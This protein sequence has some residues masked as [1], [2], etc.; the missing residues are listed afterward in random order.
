[1]KAFI[2][3][4]LFVLAHGRCSW[5]SPNAMFPRRLVR[6]ELRN[7]TFR[8]RRRL[9]LARSKYADDHKE[10]LKSIYQVSTK[11]DKNVH[12]VTGAD[13]E[14]N[15]DQAIHPNAM[16]GG[17][18]VYN[19]Y[20]NGLDDKGHTQYTL[21]FDRKFAISGKMY[22]YVAAEPSVLFRQVDLSGSEDEVV[23]ARFTHELAAAL[24]YVDEIKVWIAVTT[25]CMEG[26]ELARIPFNFHV[27]AAYDLYHGYENKL[28][29]NSTSVYSSEGWISRASIIMHPAFHMHINVSHHFVRSECGQ[30]WIDSSLRVV[31]TSQFTYWNHTS[32]KYFVSNKFVGN[33]TT[34]IPRCHRRD[35]GNICS[36]IATARLSY[37]DCGR[38]VAFSVSQAVS[39]VSRYTRSIFRTP[40]PDNFDAQRRLPVPDH[41]DMRYDMCEARVCE[42]ESLCTTLH[43]NNEQLMQDGQINIEQRDVFGSGF[44]ETICHFEVIGFL[45]NIWSPHVYLRQWVG[46]NHTLL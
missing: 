8:P 46:Y 31:N 23:L 5:Q 9:R 12:V 18:Y 14:T 30:A 22:S 25:P 17:D 32:R 38:P 13:K 21:V 37:I 29:E 27:S 44:I 16:P 3:S 35:Q 4:L 41:G 43:I 40:K 28:D 7:E 24:E 15:A 39:Q 45:D 10:R 1:M 6:L 2:F 42:D 19:E 26:R 20:T 33:Q 36:V 34:S 11:D